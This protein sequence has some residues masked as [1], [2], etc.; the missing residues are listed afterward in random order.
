MKID[1]ALE[2]ITKKYSNKKLLNLR[3]NLFVLNVGDNK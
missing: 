2:Q 3:L 1:F